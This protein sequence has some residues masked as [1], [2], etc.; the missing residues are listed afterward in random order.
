MHQVSLNKALNKEVKYY[1]L[2]YLGLIGGMLFGCL[3]WMRFGMTVGILGSIIGYGFSAII[4]KS[5]HK[6]DL[7]NYIYWHLPVKNMFGGKYLP[8][9]HARCFY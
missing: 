2:S 3:V 8:P 4:A 5:W 9:S 1:G 6:G 7:Q